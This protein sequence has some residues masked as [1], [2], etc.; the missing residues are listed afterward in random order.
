[1]SVVDRLVGAAVADQV[2]RDHAVALRRERQNRTPIQVRP[3]RVSVDEQDRLAICGSDVYVVHA[4]PVD[5]GVARLEIVF[6]EVFES[7]VGSADEQHA[8]FG[9]A[10]FGAVRVAAARRPHQKK[11][12]GTR[13]QSDSP[14]RAS[15]IPG[16]MESIGSERLR[17]VQGRHRETSTSTGCH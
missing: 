3:G 15:G 17:I 11:H 5:L 13:Q 2:W 7:L 8:R 10:D 9:P 12:T 1:M 4:Q 14:A 16:L 6:F